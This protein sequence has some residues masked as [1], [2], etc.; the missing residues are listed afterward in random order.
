[1]LVKVLSHALASGVDYEKTLKARRN[2][3]VLGIGCFGDRELV[4][5]GS[6]S[7]LRGFSQ[8]CL[9]RNRYRLNV[10]LRPVLG[11]GKKIAEGSGITEE[12]PDSGAG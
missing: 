12:D 4:E 10:I 5:A 3:S 8:G 7:C 11:E 2:L 1:M 6:G 9:Y